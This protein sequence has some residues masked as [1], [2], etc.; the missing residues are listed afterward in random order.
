VTVEYGSLLAQVIPVVALAILF[1]L[2]AL[3]ALSD[4]REE[5][6]SDASDNEP[7][8]HAERVILGQRTVVGNL[9]IFGALLIMLAQGEAAALLAAQGRAIPHLEVALATATIVDSFLFVTINPF[10]LEIYVRS[11][12]RGT[13]ILAGIYWFFL[14][15]VAIGVWAVVTG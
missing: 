13:R 14:V 8:D 7:P 1:E 6:R 10:V 15:L 4:K 3:I 5:S 2:R 12:K 11:G 9:V